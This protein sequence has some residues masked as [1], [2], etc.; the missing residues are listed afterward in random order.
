MRNV[1]VDVIRKCKK[2]MHFENCS[3]FGGSSTSGTLTSTDSNLSNKD[4]AN[5]TLTSTDSNHSVT[6]ARTS[7]VHS[8]SH[9]DDLG[10]PSKA[11]DLP[12]YPPDK[13]ASPSRSTSGSD[14]RQI[15]LLERLTKT[16]P[17][18]F[19]PTVGRSGAVHLLKNRD[20][21]IFIVRKSS[22]DDIMALSVQF[23]SQDGTQNVDHYL[24]EPTEHGLHLQGSNKLFVTIPSLVAHYCDNKEDLPH[25]LMLPPSVAVAKTSQELAAL[26]MLGQ[27]FWTST[28]YEGN[29]RCSSRS[30]LSDQSSVLNKS[31]SEPIS[32]NRCPSVP[33]YSHSETLIQETQP[34]HSNKVIDFSSYLIQNKKSLDL[35]VEST[36]SESQS[37]VSQTVTS[38][39]E[40]VQSHTKCSSSHSSSHMTCLASSHMTNHVTSH[41]NTIDFSILQQR[42][43]QSKMMMHESASSPSLQPCSKREARQSVPYAKPN[44]TQ[45][46]KERTASYCSTAI[47]L[48]HI[49][50]DFYFT[51]NLSDK[52][53][54]YEDIWKNNYSDPKIGSVHKD[55]QQRL[56]PNLIVSGNSS[57]G[58]SV[59]VVK[60]LTKSAT[61]EHTK[62]CK[63]ECF[64]EKCAVKDLNVS[65]DKLAASTEATTVT[66]TASIEVTKEME[67]SVTK[68]TCTELVSE[69]QKLKNDEN[70]NESKDVILDELESLS[71]CED[72]AENEQ[73]QPIDGVQVGFDVIPENE[74]DIDTCHSDCC[75][76]DGDAD[77]DTEEES[78]P[79]IANVH[80][81]TSP[82]W[83]LKSP[84][85]CNV[86][87][88]SVS[89]SSLSTIRSP[90][91][92]E[93]FDAIN[94]GKKGDNVAPKLPKKLRRRSAPAL[95]QSKRKLSTN[96]NKKF[97]PLVA[98]PLEEDNSAELEAN[99]AEESKVKAE[100]M[101]EPEDV[102][103]LSLEI[104][105]ALNVRNTQENADETHQYET[106][107]V[108]N[109]KNSD[110]PVKVKQKPLP[111]QTAQCTNK[112]EETNRKTFHE[113]ANRIERLKQQ[114]LEK[115][116]KMQQ[117]YNSETLEHIF[118]EFDINHNP[119]SPTL[120]KFPVFQSHISTDTNAQ[121][122]ESTAEDIICSYNPELTL[123][124]VRPFPVPINAPSEYDNLNT[125]SYLA[126]SGLS[127]ASAGTVFCKPWENSVVGKIMNTTAH[128]PHQHHTPV[129]FPPPS[130]APPP[131]PPQIDMLE[132]IKAW[133]ESSQ[134]YQSYNLDE[135]VHLGF[136][137]VNSIS[138]RTFGAEK[139]STYDFNVS[140]TEQTSQSMKTPITSNGTPDGHGPIYGIGFR[141][142]V[143][144][145]LANPRLLKKPE[146]NR[147]P[148]KHIHD[149]I[150]VLATDKTTTF[151][152]T[153]ENF[154]QCTLESSDLNPFNV[155][156]NVRQFMNGIKNYLVKHGEGELEALIERERN[157]LGKDEI[158]NID[159]IL[160]TSLHEC[161][162]QPLKQHIYRLFVNEYTRNGNLKLLSSNIKYA[163][164]KTPEEIG[165]RK[166]LVL[167]DGSTLENIKHFLVQMQKSFS[168]VK[169][170]ENLLG[171]TSTIYKCVT[172][173]HNKG[174]SSQTCFG[175]DD[176]L[177]LLI[178]VLVQCGTVSVEIEADYMWGLLHP[179]LLTGEGGYYLTSLSSAVL[180]LKNFQEMQETSAAQLEGGHLPSI[181]DMQ[182]F[183]KI[184]I[185]DEQQDTI[186]WQ[187]L[188]V[189]PSMTT[190]DVCAMIAH[191]FKI[192]NPQDYGLYTLENG[193]EC[194]M[195]DM[196]CPQML[197]VDRLAH[198]KECIF[199][200]KRNAANI[201][202]PKSVK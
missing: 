48:L 170:L 151:G 177:P 9:L 79:K 187:T 199:A 80:T 198:K 136:S 159:A 44:K 14:L 194:K 63:E 191:K 112:T 68:V 39:S 5:G 75:H 42:D 88:K 115:E 126:T 45:K 78:V 96:E 83:K 121:V 11:L 57:N 46:Q 143:A 31:A 102:F 154:I 174:K 162:I 123:R 150:M 2:P 65:L 168:P 149:Y 157:Q 62:V 169:K 26:A 148:D 98:S 193:E 23:P 183:M 180:V 69:K 120:N 54:D 184:A 64:K 92:A 7:S 21:G 40:S 197:K 185:P 20:I 6:K 202:W 87:R 107:W 12:T 24:I 106:A 66:A 49:P 93:P 18:W 1:Q 155:T 111:R 99:K 161:V 37:S 189:R 103:E 77:A 176:F 179:S 196:E 116:K 27:D 182:G 28:K 34:K 200:Y 118:Q 186:M 144:P 97:S 47:E 101:G 131:L 190:R 141:D 15:T 13:Q 56:Q 192:T 50:D 113:V 153:I 147:N 17:I 25:R 70:Q 156:R 181:S 55:L 32:I 84:P 130:Q 60:A 164:T 119:S 94:S 67:S 128:M 76:S 30:N 81:Q 132:R 52:L 43:F 117:K 142:K 166:G 163:R 16:H 146:R 110:K 90:V 35:V 91:Y 124:P 82:L 72:E 178:Y 41:V 108:D 127:I 100:S 85:F 201:A 104:K 173:K 152:S 195:L 137:D 19:L 172:S 188:P 38:V 71:D 140:S 171:A 36:S 114:T 59:A 122:A 89:T 129:K 139:S 61:E 3:A 29:S 125:E 138:A 58:A 33:A 167:P 160:E 22:R 51:S 95:S 158:L 74:S 165:I 8:V 134:K 10:T 145:I 73:L 109:F 86:G 4:V 53:S 175:A 135:D 105:P 133:Q